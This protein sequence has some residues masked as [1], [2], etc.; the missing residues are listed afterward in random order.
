MTP[1]YKR[2]V[3]FNR[4]QFGALADLVFNP[5][6]YTPD[7]RPANQPLYFQNLKKTKE[8]VN[9]TNNDWY[10]LSDAIEILASNNHVKDE[11]ADNPY[12]VSDRT[13]SLTKEGLLAFKKNQYLKEYETEQIND[14]KNDITR[15]E[16]KQK[17]YWLRNDLLKI[18]ISAI[19]GALLA[20]IPKLLEQKP[21][22]QLQKQPLSTADTIIVKLNDPTTDIHSESSYKAK[23]TIPNK[24]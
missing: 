9:I 2:H 5:V 3:G 6:E 8:Q 11:G 15:L 21:V 13:I 4:M 1:I 18:V 14:L 17:K 22:Y 20:S 16:L 23:D 10:N 7:K 19:L 24:K 12:Q